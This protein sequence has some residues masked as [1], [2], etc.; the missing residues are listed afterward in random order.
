MLVDQEISVLLENGVIQKVETVQEQFLSNLF[1]VR[2]KKSSC[3]KSKKTQ[4]I[5]P[6]IAPQNGMFALSNIFSRTKRL[7]VQ[8]TS[9]GRLLLQSQFF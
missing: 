5:Y 7:P 2:K 3:D 1:I 8:D 4:Y 9:Q 6:L